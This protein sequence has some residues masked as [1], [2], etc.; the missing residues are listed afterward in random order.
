MI[1]HEI[2]ISGAE[3]ASETSQLQHKTNT[4]LRCH[5]QIFSFF[6]IF[7]FIFFCRQR[8]YFSKENVNNDNDVEKTFHF[9][10]RL[11]VVMTVAYIPWR[12]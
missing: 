12:P 5:G 7:F 3:G 6:K 4:A 10:L 1:P 11:M 9:L 8:S 2:P